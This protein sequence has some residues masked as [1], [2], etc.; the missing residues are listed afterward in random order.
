MLGALT[1][2]GLAGAAGLNAFVPMLLVGLLARYTTLVVLPG[3]WEWLTDGWLL[4]G[5]GA[6]LLVEVVADKI[7]AVDSVND[8]LQTLVRPGAGGVVFGAGSS[9]TTFAVDETSDL[10]TTQQWIPVLSGVVVALVVHLLKSSVR[11]VVTFVTL[12]VGGPVVSA[13]EDGTSVALASLAV[14]APVVAVLLLAAVAVVLVRL[15][16][17]RSEPRR[18][19]DGLGSVP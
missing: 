14:L 7:P 2:I 10:L 4:T 1:G 12:G 6:L 13:I 8:V 15:V 3:G 16:V 17:R 9:S 18:T 5:L 19:S 11:P